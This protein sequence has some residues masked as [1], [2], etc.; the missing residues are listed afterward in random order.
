MPL[1]PTT[2]TTVTPSGTGPLPQG[3]EKDVPLPG[4]AF[5]A[6]TLLS[7]GKSGHNRHHAD[8]ASAR[9]GVACGRL[10][11]PSVS[12]NAS[13]GCTTSVGGVRPVPPPTAPDINHSSMY[14]SWQEIS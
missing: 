8:P 2:S 7:F 4:A 13:A 10:D 3:H 11:P 14:G 9:H 1:T 5:L 6:L 12:S